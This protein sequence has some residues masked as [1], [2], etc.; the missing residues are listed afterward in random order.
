MEK[1]WGSSHFFL[2]FFGCLRFDVSLLISLVIAPYN[3]SCLCCYQL[4]QDTLW[5]KK[6]KRSNPKK[7]LIFGI[8]THTPGKI[9]QTRVRIMHT[10]V[11]RIE[12]S[13]HRS[14]QRQKQF[15]VRLSLSLSLSF[16]LHPPTLS[17]NTKPPPQ[18]VDRRP[19]IRLF[20]REKVRYFN[21]R[22]IRRRKI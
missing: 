19:R 6:P 15:M 12:G 13:Q 16:S 17:L 1:I 4:L 22:T 5:R 21:E 10:Q 9:Q 8:N 7:L 11:W 18:K 14:R 2:V 20:N 3:V